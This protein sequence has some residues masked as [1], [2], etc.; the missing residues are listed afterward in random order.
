MFWILYFCDKREALKESWELRGRAV[1]D[2]NAPT[3][4][5]SIN[6][7]WKGHLWS[8]HL[9]KQKMN[10]SLFSENFLTQ[11]KTHCCWKCACKL[12]DRYKNRCKNKRWLGH[13]AVLFIAV[14]K[15]SHIFDFFSFHQITASTYSLFIHFSLYIYTRLLNT[16]K[17]IKIKR[18]TPFLLPSVEFAFLFVCFF[19]GGSP[20]TS[21]TH[22]KTGK[23]KN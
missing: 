10:F 13:L 22:R 14:L 21:R 23:S 8:Y 12:D 1:K 20:C 2:I 4:R 19:A 16:G 18:L 3:G 17:P 6:L 7:F 15:N 5:A 9:V 11:K